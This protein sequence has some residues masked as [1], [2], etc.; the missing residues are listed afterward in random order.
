M[1]LLKHLFHR[2]RMTD[3]LSEEM[4]QHLDEKIEA[5]VAQG[6]SREEAVHAARRAFGNATLLEQRGSEVWM[7]PWIESIWADVKFALR[8]L[9][10]SPGFTLR[11][12]DAGAR[13]WRK[14]GDLQ[15]GGCSSAS[16][17]TSAESGRTGRDAVV[18]TS[19]A[20]GGHQ[21]LRGLWAS[22]N[23]GGL[24]RVLLFLSHVSRDYRTQRPVFKC[25]GV[26]GAGANGP[27]REWASKCRAGR[28]GIEELFCDTGRGSGG[29]PDARRRR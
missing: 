23:S 12:L 24:Q 14:F 22:K 5:L 19:V 8:Q 26:C 1:N 11:C 6:M 29:G 4:R 7:W 15:P 25:D 3:D 27:E 16:V 13:N 17:A 18:G 20:A 28:T 9:R 21:Q 10:K 2:R